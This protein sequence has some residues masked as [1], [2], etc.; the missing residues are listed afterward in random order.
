MELSLSWHRAVMPPPTTA[1]DAAAALVRPTPNPAAPMLCK[2]A[3]VP[4]A[5]T[6]PPLAIASALIYC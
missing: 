5:I 2:V 4:P 1:P 6:P 3:T